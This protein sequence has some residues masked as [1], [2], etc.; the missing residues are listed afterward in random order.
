MAYYLREVDEKQHQRYMQRALELAGRGKGVVSPNPMV[1]AVLVHNETIISEGWHHQYGD[2]H[3]EVDCIQNVPSS[4]LHLIP[5]STLY[6][7]LEPCAHHGKQPPCAP[8]ILQEGIKKIVV[9][10]DDPFEK[11]S[12]K[13]FE[14]LAKGGVDI[15]RRIC[16][17]QGLWLN[18][19]FFTFHKNKRPYIVLKWAQSAD[20][21]VAPANRKRTTISNH[22]SHTLTHKWRTEESAIAVGYNTALHDNPQL[23]ARLWKGKQPLRIVVDSNLTLPQ[24]H[25]LLDSG[26]ETW[27]FNALKNFSSDKTT[28]IKYQ[29]AEMLPERMLQRL[30]EAGHTS[31]IIEGGAIFLA[32]FINAGLWDEA[33]IFSSKRTLDDGIQ[34]PT[35]KDARLAVTTDIANDVLHIFQKK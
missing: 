12:G 27:I 2:V 13:G 9:C 24:T 7:T 20:G 21:F 14:I 6:V 19:R 32:S 34:A 10:N 22:Y 25:A 8:R 30:S 4:L 35:L 16:A 28:F 18:R 33:R 5:E 29:A 31:I 3:A 11:V 17:S 1:G 15:T 23:T 26:A